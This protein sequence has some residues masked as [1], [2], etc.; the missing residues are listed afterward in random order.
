MRYL[1][2]TILLAGWSSLA[3][4]ATNCSSTSG[5]NS[6]GSCVP[7]D[8]DGINGIGEGVH[9]V[10]VNVSD[11]AFAV[12]GVDSGSTE[13][14]IATQ[15]LDSVTLT[16]TNVG[17]KPHD[18]VIQCIPSGLPAGCP[19]TSCFPGDAG[20][21]A[22]YVTLVPALEPGQST[23]TSFVTP[24]VEGE[25]QFISDEPGD[26]KSDADGGLTG[27]VGDFVLM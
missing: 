17:N 5:G 13:R 20:L 27:L 16:L 26:T 3:F 25:Y 22:G 19:Q 2:A 12:G 7:G 21:P 1:R 18:M 11:T 9:P 23:T 4:A 8:N 10:L 15:N 24:A 6:G 14:N